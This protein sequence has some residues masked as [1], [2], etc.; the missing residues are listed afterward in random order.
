MHW[1]AGDEGFGA[2]GEA[3]EVEGLAGLELLAFA[4]EIGVDAALV[5]GLRMCGQHGE[6]QRGK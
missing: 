5:A 6:H 4:A 2:V 3:A 1:L